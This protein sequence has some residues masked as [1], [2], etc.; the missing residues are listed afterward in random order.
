MRDDLENIYMLVFGFVGNGFQ[1]ALCNVSWLAT[2][3]PSF[4]CPIPSS[5]HRGP[6][7]S[8]EASLVTAVKTRHTKPQARV[9]RVK[10]PRTGLSQGK[11]APSVHGACWRKV[12]MIQEALSHAP[13]PVHRQGDL[14]DEVDG[15]QGDTIKLRR[16]DDG[17]RKRGV[18]C[19]HLARHV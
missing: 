15:M 5:S 7:C 4:P 3:S 8:T 19:V 10:R 18:S 14:G 12:K 6:C 16:D 2:G 13:S 11:L 9:S 17:S 1:L